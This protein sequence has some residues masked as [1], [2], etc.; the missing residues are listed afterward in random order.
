MTEDAGRPRA[1][2]RRGYRRLRRPGRP[3]P[4]QPRRVRSR[5]RRPG[6]AVV[7]SDPATAALSG[8]RR[9]VRLVADLSR[10]RRR[11]TST[12]G[13]WSCR[14]VRPNSRAPSRFLPRE[15]HD[16][17]GE[18]REGEGHQEAEALQARVRRADGRGKRR[19]GYDRAKDADRIIIADEDVR[20]SGQ[21]GGSFTREERERR[22]REKNQ[23]KQLKNPQTRLPRTGSTSSRP[24]SRCPRATRASRRCPERHEEADQRLTAQVAKSTASMAKYNA[25]IP[26]DEKIKTRGRRR[27]FD[28]VTDTGTERERAR[29]SSTN[30]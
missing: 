4:R 26:G 18:V 16:Q 1:H 11:R 17:V 15:A 12:A 3:R 2:P 13:T 8:A 27:Q 19:H 21:D 10:R 20:R 14:R 6:R 25:P 5:A 28:S 7:P 24:R 22:A 23:G 30:W 9:A 29:G